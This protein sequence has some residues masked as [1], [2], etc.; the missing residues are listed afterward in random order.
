MK[1]WNGDSAI[2]NSGNGMAVTSTEVRLSVKDLDNLEWARDF[3]RR[4]EKK[5]K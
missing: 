1:I 4:Y 2:K 5:W 3:M